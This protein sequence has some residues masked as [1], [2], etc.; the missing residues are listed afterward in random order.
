[1]ATK[2]FRGNILGDVTQIGES[3]GHGT[4]TWFKPDH[5]IFEETEFDF[6]ILQSR[7]RELAFLKQGNS[8]HLI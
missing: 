3:D 2:I 7:L 1:M 8:Y 4:K 5:E 6:D